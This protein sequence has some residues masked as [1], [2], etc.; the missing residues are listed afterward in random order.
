MELGGFSMPTA[1]T[2]WPHHSWGC[3]LLVHH[4][5][6]VMKV[7][8]EFL[9]EAGFRVHQAKGALEAIDEELPFIPHVV[10][11]GIRLPKLSGIE[12]GKLLHKNGKSYCIRFILLGDECDRS[13]ARH[14]I[15]AD[16]GVNDFIALPAP[17]D[18][19]LQKVEAHARIS[20][21]E[22]T[23]GKIYKILD[24]E[25]LSPQAKLAS[26]RRELE[27]ADA[28][29]PLSRKSKIRPLVA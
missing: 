6:R 8:T 22:R 10:L 20:R 27:K 21:L 18:S 12:L 2:T 15:E 16:D 25:K 17:K 19:L 1:R 7:L 26:I 9:T 11:A 29:M 24:D 3:V 5:S 23:R 14:A 28:S 13:L 4:E